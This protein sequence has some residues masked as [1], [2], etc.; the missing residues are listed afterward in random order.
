[1]SSFN[2]NGIKYGVIW[3]VI[4]TLI[5]T[6]IQGL[7]NI[8]KFATPSFFMSE[9]FLLSILKSVFIGIIT[10]SIFVWDFR[11]ISVNKKS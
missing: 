2:K 7:L 9:S 11:K 10:A 6:L 5:S 4:F 8:D 1:M 3:I